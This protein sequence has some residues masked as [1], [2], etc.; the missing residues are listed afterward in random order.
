ATTTTAAILHGAAA[1]SARSA[2]AILRGPCVAA[3]SASAVLRAAAVTAGS[4]A[5]AVTRVHTTAPGSGPSIWRRWGAR[6]TGCDQASAD[7]ATDDDSDPHDDP[8]TDGK[9]QLRRKL[10]MRQ[11]GWE[12]RPRR[13]TRPPAR[14]LSGQRCRPGSVHPGTCS[15]QKRQQALPSPEG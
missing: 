10:A 6:S 1:V 4:T 2:S 7:R 3:R 8:R 11:V 5:A 14:Q 15:A 9:R 13:G 12:Y